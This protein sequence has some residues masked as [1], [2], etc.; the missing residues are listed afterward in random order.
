MR[1][2]RRPEKDTGLLRMTD[3]VDE[4]ATSHKTLLAM[5]EQLT[6]FFKGGDQFLSTYFHPQ[7]PQKWHESLSFFR[8]QPT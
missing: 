7:F 8:F 6:P 2:S 4:I 5:T 1:F 3:W